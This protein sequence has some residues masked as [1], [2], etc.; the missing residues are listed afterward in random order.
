MAA[1]V[2]LARGLG[3]NAAVFSLTGAMLFRPVPYR[4]GDRLATVFE[5]NQSR[6][7]SNVA[8]TPFNYLTW[9][10]RVDAFEQTAVFVRVHFNISTAMKAV[11]VE[12][13]RAAANLFPL[14]GME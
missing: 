14:I 2:T 11:Q 5:A 4:D 6:G 1:V 3:V 8:P 9:R 12:G 13:F 7:I 10:D